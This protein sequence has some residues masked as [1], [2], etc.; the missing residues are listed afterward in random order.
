[1]LNILFKRFTNDFTE[2]PLFNVS[3]KEDG[4]FEIS[5]HPTLIRDEFISTQLNEL[6]KHIQS[7]EEKLTHVKTLF[8]VTFNLQQYKQH[9]EKGSCDLKLHSRL[10]GYEFI[11]NQLNGLVDH[12]RKNYDM[13]DLCE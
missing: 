9:G 2:V 13:R 12:I 6:T 4:S 7:L 8:Y 3:M 11:V 10:R 5:L 1:M